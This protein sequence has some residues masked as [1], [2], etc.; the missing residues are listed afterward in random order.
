MMPSFDGNPHLNLMDLTLLTIVG[1]STFMNL[2]RSVKRAPEVN[3]IDRLIGSATRTGFGED[4]NKMIKKSIQKMEF[5]SPEFSDKRH[6][7]NT[8]KPIL[9]YHHLG[10]MTRELLS[11]LNYD[12]DIYELS[13]PN[14]N[15]KKYLYK[16]FGTTDMS[17]LAGKAVTEKQA[18]K[19]ILLALDSDATN[20]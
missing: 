20:T 18:H 13:S 9:K 17:A 16:V 5:L 8:E 6:T 15:T 19:L 2:C 11:L 7:E 3:T 4:V 10:F 12:N 1:P 14:D